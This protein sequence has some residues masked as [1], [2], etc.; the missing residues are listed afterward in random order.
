M[1]QMIIVQTCVPAPKMSSSI[2][3][4]PVPSSS[5]METVAKI[6]SA[7]KGC[8]AEHKDKQRIKVTEKNRGKIEKDAI[9]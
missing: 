8:V 1:L 2:V 4:P 9:F 7:S 5:G 6:S 3:L